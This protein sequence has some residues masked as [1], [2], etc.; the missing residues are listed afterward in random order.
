VIL[1]KL[2]SGDIQ[3]ANAFG[4]DEDIVRDKRSQ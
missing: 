1:V 2:N 3:E 4:G